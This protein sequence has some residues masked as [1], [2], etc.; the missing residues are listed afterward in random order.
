MVDSWLVQQILNEMEL[1]EGDVEK[2]KK[3]IED[4][5]TECDPAYIES[6]GIPDI[7]SRFKEYMEKPMFPL[8]KVKEFVKGW[9][10]NMYSISWGQMLEDDP[11][12][13]EYSPI[14]YEEDFVTHRYADH[15]TE[16][17]TLK[18]LKYFDLEED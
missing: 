5:L 11:D 2:R 9:P 6:H 10:A 17:S 12:G 3:D 13:S 14:D 8:D 7:A 1:D 4:W 15:Y 16:R 18:V